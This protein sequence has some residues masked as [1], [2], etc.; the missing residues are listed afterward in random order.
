MPSH[1]Q[2]VCGLPVWDCCVRVNFQESVRV[3]RM[4]T[5]RRDAGLITENEDVRRFAWTLF[6]RLIYGPVGLFKI[7]CSMFETWY[8][9]FKALKPYLAQQLCPYV[10]PVL[11]TLLWPNFFKFLQ[12]GLQSF[13]VCSNSLELSRCLTAFVTVNLLATFRK[14]FILNRHSVSHPSDRLVQHLRFDFSIF[15]R[16]FIN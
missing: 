9:L 10:L 15:C 4:T 6:F 8:I 3:V 14:Y 5:V 16:H 1:R 13:H 11:N 12:F 7:R 2:S